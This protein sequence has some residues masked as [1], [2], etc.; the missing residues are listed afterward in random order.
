MLKAKNDQ[1]DEDGWNRRREYDYLTS[2]NEKRKVGAP[3]DSMPTS[4]TW[5]SFSQASNSRMPSVWVANL[6][7][8]Y[9]VMR[10]ILPR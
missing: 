2:P 4:V 9:S 5:H 3:V 10:R 7:L 8:W 6:R 1:P